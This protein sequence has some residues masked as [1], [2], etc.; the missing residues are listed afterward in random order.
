MS[1]PYRLP[2]DI[3][4]HGIHALI[5][6]F[7]RHP[8][9]KA[10]TQKG[11]LVPPSEQYIPLNYTNS[12]PPLPPPDRL[13]EIHTLLSSTTSIGVWSLILRPCNNLHDWRNAFAAADTVD[14]TGVYDWDTHANSLVRLPSRAH[15]RSVPLMTTAVLA[16]SHLCSGTFGFFTS[17][18]RFISE[19]TRKATLLN[20]NEYYLFIA[21]AKESSSPALH[22]KILR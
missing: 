14:I 20:F 11:R 22:L 17:F 16:S 4:V 7:N 3:I 15:S 1:P 12:Q 13:N 5:Q 18:F 8:L 6:Q 9:T 19:G 2:Q 10:H 21:F